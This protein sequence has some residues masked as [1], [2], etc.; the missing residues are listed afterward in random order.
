MPPVGIVG[1]VEWMVAMWLVG[2]G[3]ALCIGQKAGMRW[4][5]RITRRGISG[6]RRLIG[7]LFR[8]FAGT[9]CVA[10]GGAA[11]S[12]TT[13]LHNF[14]Y[15]RWPRATLAVYGASLLVIVTIYALSR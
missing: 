14:F 9:V 11:V 8:W 12:T 4:Y 3:L 1:L 15:S 6:L 10:V 7:R 5:M 2:L 13:A